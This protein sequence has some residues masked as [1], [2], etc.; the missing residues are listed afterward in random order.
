MEIGLKARRAKCTIENK[1]KTKEFYFAL[2]AWIHSPFT[3]ASVSQTARVSAW[4]VIFGP[5]GVD[6]LQPESFCHND[7]GYTLKSGRRD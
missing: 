2:R 1:I 4:A 6:L 3:Q 5:S 7:V